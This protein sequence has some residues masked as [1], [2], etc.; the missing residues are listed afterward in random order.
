MKSITPDT[1]SFAA[2]V[3]RRKAQAPIFA[4]KRRAVA[5]L[6]ILEQS[7]ANALQADNQRTRDAN[8]Y[9]KAQAE[10]R[11]LF[12][13]YVKSCNAA[14]PAKA[15]EAAKAARARSDAAYAA[16]DAAQ[17]AAEA[18]AEVASDAAA[19]AAQAATIAREAV[20]AA[21]AVE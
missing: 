4:A 20:E 18:A 3:A 17:A 5:L 7:N 14:N 2:R 11:D 9:G 15:V 8:A 12:A 6:A 1:E 19:E 21:K 16:S 10:Y 13:A